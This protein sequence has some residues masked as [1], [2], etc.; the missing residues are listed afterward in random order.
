MSSKDGGKTWGSPARIAPL[1]TAL[2]TNPDIPNPTSFDETVRAGDYLPD[3]AVNKTTG[4]IYMVFATDVDGS[5][6]NHVVLTKST[7]GGKKWSTPQRVD[8]GTPPNT[9]S[10]NGTVEVTAD[11]TVAVM[12]YDFRSNTSAAGLP[13]GVFLVHS[14]DGGAT[15]TEQQVGGTFDMENAPVARGWFLGDYQG[16]AAAGEDFN[17]LILFYSVATGAAN[18]ADVMAVRATRP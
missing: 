4:A 9:H 8:V 18:S 6:W 5:G 13:T 2:L 14:H 10:F 17:D 15:W 12:F 3:V 11:G 16:M 7:D 1:G